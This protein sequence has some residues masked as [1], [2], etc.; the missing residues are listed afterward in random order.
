M[1]CFL[2]PRNDLVRRHCYQPQYVRERPAEEGICAWLFFGIT[3]VV[4][5]NVFICHNQTKTA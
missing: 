4:G 1:T 3:S 5:I 2:R